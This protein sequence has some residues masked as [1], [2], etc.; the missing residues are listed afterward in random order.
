L[1]DY[2]VQPFTTAGIR[3]LQGTLDFLVSTNEAK[4]FSIASWE[5]TA[6]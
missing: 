1:S 4:P 2:P 5:A 6:G 3:Q